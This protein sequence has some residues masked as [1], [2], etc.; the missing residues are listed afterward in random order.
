MFV[1]QSDFLGAGLQAYLS[2]DLF[3]VSCGIKELVG[4]NLLDM[5]SG[6]INA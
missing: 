3:I 2:V 6:N 4:M 1:N 5:T